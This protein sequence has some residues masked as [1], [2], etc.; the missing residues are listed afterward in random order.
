LAPRDLTTGEA[1]SEYLQDA[2]PETRHVAD[3]SSTLPVAAQ[4]PP[5][6][7]VLDLMLP[8]IDGLEV[9]RRLLAGAERNV[10]VD[11]EVTAVDSCLGGESGVVAA[12]H[13][14]DADPNP[15][16]TWETVR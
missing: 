14:V 3:G 11:A 5:G 13:R 8:G 10:E 4:Y 16:R 15:L 7:V 9:C 2:G 1:V 12:V 6:L